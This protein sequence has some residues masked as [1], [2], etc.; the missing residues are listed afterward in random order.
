MRIKI[1]KTNPKLFFKKIRSLIIKT[2]I[3]VLLIKI[4]NTNMVFK[5]SQ[6]KIKII[7]IINYLK[8]HI[9]IIFN[10]KFSSLHKILIIIRLVI[11]N[12]LKYN[13]IKNKITIHNRIVTENQSTL[14][15][16]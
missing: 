1:A 10:I 9:M 12:L 7:F 6:N 5:T 16:N 13:Q 8:T 14:L 3:M 11:K 2:L 4:I 15:P